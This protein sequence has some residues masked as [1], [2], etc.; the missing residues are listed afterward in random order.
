MVTPHFATLAQGEAM[1]AHFQKKKMQLVR[2]LGNSSCKTHEN[3]S[4][5][6]AFLQIKSNSGIHDVWK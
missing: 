1:I 3:H 2:L 4:S 5:G 6:M